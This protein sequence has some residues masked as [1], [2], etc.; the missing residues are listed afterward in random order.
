MREALSQIVAENVIN[1]L[2]D[3]NKQLNLIVANILDL[4]EKFTGA[5]GN[6]E[7]YKELVDKLYGEQSRSCLW[8]IHRLRRLIMGHSMT[9]LRGF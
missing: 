8:D 2:N 7:A 9:S 6:P 4:Y 5:V 1:A 3:K